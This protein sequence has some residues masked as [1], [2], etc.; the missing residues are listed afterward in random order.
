VC[1][2]ILTAITIARKRGVEES[3]VTE[4]EAIASALKEKLH[5]EL[6]AAIRSVSEVLGTADATTVKDAD[7]DKVDTVLA[8]ALLVDYSG[9]DL[10]SLRTRS[11]GL[12]S[13]QAKKTLTVRLVD[14][15]RLRNADTLQRVLKSAE[16]LGMHKEPSF[17]LAAQVL[18]ILQEKARLVEL[19]DHDGLEEN[20]VK[21]TAAA[22][23]ALQVG[24]MPTSF[25]DV[26]NSVFLQSLNA[27]RRR[28]VEIVKSA[29]DED[30]DDVLE[31]SLADQVL[32]LFHAFVSMNVCNMALLWM[33]N[34]TNLDSRRLVNMQAATPL[35]KQSLCLFGGSVW[36]R[37]DKQRSTPCNLVHL[38]SLLLA[39]EAI[40]IRKCRC[41]KG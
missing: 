24:N 11:R 35:S 9:T 33:I 7:L 3:V 12:R 29:D 22:N 30:E 41:S 17:E 6:A 23:N 40:F 37:M 34:R 26:V 5:A 36:P 21:L 15:L 38:F 27:N 13:D 4:A 2:V 32:L 20:R 39:R 8:D 25:S 18:T 16:A 1:C 28:S 14:G 19:G 10:E 31:V